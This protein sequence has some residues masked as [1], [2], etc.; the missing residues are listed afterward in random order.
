ML[1]FARLKAVGSCVSDGNGR[2]HRQAIMVAVQEL[3]EL[4]AK[5]ASGVLVDQPNLE[6]TCDVF[7]RF[8]LNINLILFQFV[9]GAHW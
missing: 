5:N 1:Y 7:I 4:L 9:G 3:K 8:V 2:W 6:R